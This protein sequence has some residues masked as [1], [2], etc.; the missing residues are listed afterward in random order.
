MTVLFTI[1]WG[2]VLTEI[3]VS[4]VGSVTGGLDGSQGRGKT[5]KAG[6]SGISGRS[7]GKG[8]S[9]GVSGSGSSVGVSGRGKSC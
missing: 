3:N 4:G 1:H 9:G 8:K 5:S 2:Q 7:R 6:G